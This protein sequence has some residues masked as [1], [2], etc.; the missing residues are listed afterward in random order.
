MASARFDPSP[1]RRRRAFS[2]RTLR[3]RGTAGTQSSTAGSARRPT[4]M[5]D[6]AR[7]GAGTRVLDIAAGSGGQSI[8]AARRGAIVLATDI[9]SNILDEAAAAAR[10][11][12]V[13]DH[14][15]P[16]HGR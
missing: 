1:T 13:V 9:S 14:R 6:L 10:A 15:D 12:G 5:L 16:G 11:A 8:A 4:L 7:V 2:G 3:R